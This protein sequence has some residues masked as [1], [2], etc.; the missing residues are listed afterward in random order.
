[1]ETYGA[2]G[3]ALI[4]VEVS[5]YHRF[6]RVVLSYLERCPHFRGVLIAIDN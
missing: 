3:T 6:V 2:N 1:M 5:S 4:V